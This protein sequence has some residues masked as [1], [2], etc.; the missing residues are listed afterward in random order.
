M[1]D[2]LK[3][4]VIENKDVIPYINLDAENKYKG[5][6]HNFGIKLP[7]NEDMKLNLENEGDLFLLFVLASSWS[8]TGQWENAA[9]FTTYLKHYDKHKLDLW[10]DDDFIN[11]EIQNRKKNASEFS[12]ICSG[13]KPRRKVSF[14]KKEQRPHPFLN[15]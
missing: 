9:F 10:L 15:G 5:W 6:T 7:N 1:I 8:K 13:V 12:S 11:N 2:R 14:R 3:D 4:A